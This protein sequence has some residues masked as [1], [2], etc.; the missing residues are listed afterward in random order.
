[1]DQ[2][3]AEVKDA[4]LGGKSIGFYVAA[5]FFAG[6]AILLSLYIH[7]RKR[8]VASINTPQR[9]SWYFLFW[10][11]SKRIFAGITVVFLILRFLSPPKMEAALAIG[12]LV[13]FGL[14]KSIELLMERF[15]FL[16]FLKSDR[17]KLPT[18]P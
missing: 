11:N 4:I 14:D 8:D 10:D 15:N 17:D 5:F 3:I 7:S 9:F 1:M 16:N 12:F 6:L 13:A 2:I 18:K